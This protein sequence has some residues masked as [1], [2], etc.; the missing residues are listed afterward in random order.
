MSF[1]IIRDPLWN[2]IRVDPLSL[3]LI[4]TPAFQRLRYVRQL[5]LAFYVYPGA[6]HARFEHALGTYHLAR[7]TLNLFEER[8]PFDSAGRDEC[9]VVRVAALLH[10]IGHYPFSH[11]LEEIGTMHHEDVARPLICSGPVADILRRELGPDSPE[12]VVSLIRG[13][14]DSPLQGLI[15]GSIDLDKLDYLRRDAFMCGVSYGEIDVDRLVNSLT[16][17]PHPDTGAPV[18]GIVEKGLSALE[19]LLFA[20]YQMYR[21]VYWHHAVRSA[22]A[23]YKR[24]VADALNAGSLDARTLAGFTDEGILHVM[25][26][27]APTPL[28]AA[29]RER[30]LYK[31]AFECPAADLPGDAG[32][33]IADDRQLTRDVETALARELGLELGE[34]LLDYP[35][36]TQMLG[37]D[38]LVLRRS[39]S[40]RRLTAEGWQG[41][42]NLPKLSE[43]FYRSAR[44]L[45]VYTAKRLTIDPHRMMALA[46]LSTGEVRARL[47]RGDRLL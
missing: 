14:S 27:R 41:S 4:D 44:W 47:E 19:S 18:V 7:R 22:T 15:S 21:N 38:L 34:L 46:Q 5:G 2:N 13:E 3:A 42:I 16:L 28:L 45:R 35:T 10:D 25:S 8:S 6:T 17:V 11:A 36:K 23:M 43:E 33:W 40:L 31:R 24:L 32:E 37:L 39:G 20:R 12:R 29:L 26:Q 1:D 30:R 9:R